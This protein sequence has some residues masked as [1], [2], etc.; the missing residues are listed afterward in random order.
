MSIRI[1]VDEPIYNN[2]LGLANDLAR[3]PS[4]DL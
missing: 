4:G 1:S 2:P 3:G